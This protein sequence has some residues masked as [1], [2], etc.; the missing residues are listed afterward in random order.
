MKVMTV[1]ELIV[2]LREIVARN[3]G[4]D[5]PVYYDTTEFYWPA[6]RVAIVDCSEDYMADFD[7]GVLISK[8]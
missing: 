6:G 4:G 2:K 3:N 7:I 1:D 5:L 8:E